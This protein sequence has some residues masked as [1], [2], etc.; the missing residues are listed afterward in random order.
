MQSL[1]IPAVLGPYGIA[2][3]NGPSDSLNRNLLAGTYL[4]TVTD[5]EGCVLTDSVIL[6]PRQP[7]T[8][9]V[10]GLP[11]QC[12][13]DNGSLQI[14]TIFGGGGFYEVSLDGE[15]FLP[16]ENVADFVIPP[17]LRRATF[18]DV[19]DCS[20]SVSFFVPGTLNPTL[21]SAPGYGH[22]HWRQYIS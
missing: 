7:L 15:F 6:N 2:W 4:V 19:D 18:Q 5:G 11:G 12:P 20:V 13:G 1:T 10:T 14:D 8:V 9:R 3:S 22:L 21:Q 16:V 17:G